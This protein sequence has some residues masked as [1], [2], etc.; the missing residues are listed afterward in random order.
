[1]NEEGKRKEGK[2][3]KASPHVWIECYLSSRFP[4]DESRYL[5]IFLEYLLL[6]S[7]LLLF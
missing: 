1:M 2:E 5:D 3:D 4:N 6:F 7:S